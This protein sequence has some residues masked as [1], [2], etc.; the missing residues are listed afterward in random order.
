VILGKFLPPHRG[1]E[2]LVNFARNYVD[3]LTVVVGTLEN[4]SIAGELRYQWM[5]QLFPGVRVL[6]LTDENP[7]YPHEHPQFWQIWRDSLKAILPEEPDYLFAS[8]TYGARL[9]RELGA[10]YIPVD[11]SRAIV[12]VSGT[13]IRDD[14]WAH[15][16][17]LPELVRAYYAI[18]VCIFGPEST[19]KT[20]LA[21][22]LAEHFQT[23]FVPEYAR[24]LLELKNGELTEVDIPRIARGQI[25]S[26]E[27]LA[28]QCNRLLFCDTDLLSTKIWSE[29]LYGS[30]PEW[31]VDV[32]AVR[33]YDLYLVTDVDVPWVDDAIRYLPEDRQ[34]FLDRCLGEL[35]ARGSRYVLLSGS[36][37]ER[38]NKACAAVESTLIRSEVAV[39]PGQ[40][41]SARWVPAKASS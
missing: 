37:E 19:G 12:P 29:T 28:S 27:A 25:A 22:N 34:P 20:T 10:Q 40:R 17:H 33:D 23:V 13:A 39:P 21:R 2:Y 4:E 5:T 18:R 38:L 7:Q 6:H 8:E 32:A 41:R 24:T 14:P 11:P 35:D 9:A 1:H 36:W 26:E 31:I 30:C 15:W 16:Q 3:D